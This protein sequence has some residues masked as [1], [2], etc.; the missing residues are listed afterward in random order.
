[1]GK[2][3]YFSSTSILFSSICS[4]DA[5]VVVEILDFQLCFFCIHLTFGSTP[6]KINRMKSNSSDFKLKKQNIPQTL[7]H[8]TI[9][10]II[11]PNAWTVSVKFVTV[12]H[13]HPIAFVVSFNPPIYFWILAN[14]TWNKS[15]M[16]LL[17]I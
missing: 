15:D 3:Y 4:C 12:D 14:P 17:F 8:A 1:M 16:F 6:S 13:E 10:G 5:M 11:H 7:I 9:P 2:H